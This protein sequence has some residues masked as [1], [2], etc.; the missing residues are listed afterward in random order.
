[1][2]IRT[3]LTLDEDIAAKLKEESRARGIP[4][5]K[6]LNDALRRGLQSMKSS[7]TRKPFKIDAV[8]LG[9]MPGLNYDN[10]GALIEHAEGEDWK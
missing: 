1:M 9:A 5:R 6:L 7:T 4:F 8:D 2:S 3:T 10:I